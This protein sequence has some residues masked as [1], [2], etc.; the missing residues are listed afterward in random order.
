MCKNDDNVSPYLRR[1]TRSW[2]EIL[3]EQA[4]RAGRVNRRIDS[5][6][7]PLTRDLPKEDEDDVE[8]RS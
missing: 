8:P 4:K 5:P 7:G 6:T 2:E 1:P 3:R